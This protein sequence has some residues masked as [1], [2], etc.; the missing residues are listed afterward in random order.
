M[1]LSRSGTCF[2]FFLSVV[3]GCSETN[4]KGSSVERRPAVADAKVGG[5]RKDNVA[6]PQ[7]NANVSSEESPEWTVENTPITHKCAPPAGLSFRLTDGLSE[8]NRYMLARF[9]AFGPAPL[10]FEQ[11]FLTGYLGKAGFSNVKVVENSQKGVQGFVATSSKLNLVVF[12]GT[13]S[14][15]GVTTDL[16][17]FMSGSS[18]GN[19]GG[20]VHAGFKDAYDSIQAN[21]NSVL[22]NAETKKKPTFFVGHS[23]G[24]ALAMLA[25]ADSL[26]KG[27]NIGG[28][29]TLGQPRTGNVNFAANFSSAL[30]EKYFRYVYA[31]DPVPHLPPSPGASFD[32]AATVTNNEILKLG[33]GASALFR[34][35]H[36]G[37]PQ[38]LGQ[39]QF[40]IESY[41]SDDAWDKS[42]WKANS[43]LGQSLTN[44]ASA[45]SNTSLSALGQNNVIGDHEVEKYLCEMVKV[46]K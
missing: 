32:A 17:F 1:S 5:E 31:N 3:S 26:S 9:A 42:F 10:K 15:G 16:N 24:G 39:A 20:G 22:S 11:T 33:I 46:S 25:A 40:A 45:G 28:L 2:V 18:F 38:K 7:E 19:V 44:L 43:T 12:R 23:L 21:L 30:R 6:G 14:A 41:V 37:V 27:V 29:I 36:V 8:T 4:K 13:H 35:G 34:F